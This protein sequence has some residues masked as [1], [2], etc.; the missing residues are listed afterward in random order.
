[1]PSAATIT[2]LAVLTTLI[3]CY[4]CPTLPATTLH[5]IYTL[6]PLITAAA[7]MYMRTLLR[8]YLYLAQTLIQ[9]L[10]SLT[11]CTLSTTRSTLWALCRLCAHVLGTLMGY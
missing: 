8:M 11:F 5:L 1:M 4:T 2:F 6:W 3:V 9:S 10:I 7:N